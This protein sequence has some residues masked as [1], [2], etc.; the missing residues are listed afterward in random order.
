MR[1]LL[2]PCSAVQPLAVTVPQAYGLA[3]ALRGSGCSADQTMRGQR[4]VRAPSPEQLASSRPRRGELPRRQARGDR[5]L[6]SSPDMI[7]AVGRRLAGDGSRPRGAAPFAPDPIALLLPLAT[8][9]ACSRC[10]PTAGSIRGVHS[11]DPDP[12]LIAP[13]AST[14]TSCLPSTAVPSP[15]F[16]ARQPGPSPV[17]P[18]PPARSGCRRSGVRCPPDLPRPKRWPKPA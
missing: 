5:L 6:V 10:A 12:A 17:R 3:G 16:A 4:R 7:G 9:L 11:A 15:T 8:R 18:D 1:R 13:D 14:M 2:L